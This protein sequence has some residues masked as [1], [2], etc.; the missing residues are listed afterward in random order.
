MV[1]IM[2]RLVCELEVKI[3]VE[4]YLVLT[5]NFVYEFVQSTFTLYTKKCLFRKQFISTIPKMV[6]ASSWLM[7]YLLVFAL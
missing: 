1:Q 5:V 2:E 3:N 7:L 4:R 6:T